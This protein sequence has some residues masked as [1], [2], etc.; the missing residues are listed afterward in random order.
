MKYSDRNKGGIGLFLVGILL[1]AASVVQLREDESV[2]VFLSFLGP[3]LLFCGVAQLLPVR[4]E[5]DSDSLSN[6]SLLSKVIMT[7]G[8]VLGALHAYALVEVWW[9][10]D[11]LISCLDILLQRLNLTQ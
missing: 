3:T 11:L 7:M 5:D 9:W 10:G 4:N 1:F 2:Y 8:F 6:V